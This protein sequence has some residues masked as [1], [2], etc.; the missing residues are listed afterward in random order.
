MMG[1]SA[2]EPIA[3]E[4]S[5]EA[6][7][8]VIDIFISEPVHFPRKT[9]PSH[10]SSRRRYHVHSGDTSRERTYFKSSRPA[11]RGMLNLSTAFLA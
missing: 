4:V 10:A 9:P 2:N 5:E 8:F 1:R 7:Y 11:G 6:V 3:K